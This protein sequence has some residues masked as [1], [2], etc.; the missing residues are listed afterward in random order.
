MDHDARVVA[1]TLR[2]HLAAHDRPLSFLFGAGTSASVNTAPLDASGKPTGYIPLIP[3][4]AGLTAACRTQVE[5]M[6][7]AQTQAWT[8]LCT[9]C[10]ALS[11][12]VDI[13]SILSR[14]RTKL[15]ALLPS[16][17]LSGLSRPQWEA[18]DSAVRM[19]IADLATPKSIP[20]RLPHHA[21][22]R[23][24]RNTTRRRAVEVFTTNYDVLFETCFDQLRVPHFDGFIGSQFSY[25][26]ADAV[27]SEEHLP[28]PSWVRLW[29]LHGSV[30]WTQETVGSEKRITRGRPVTS[31]ELILPSHRKYDES[32][33]QPYRSL[34]DRLGRILG[35]DDAL[36]I[37]CGFGFRDQHINA[38]VLDA[39]EHHPRTHLIILAYDPVEPEDTVAK[40]AA[41]HPNIVVL[42][43]NAGLVSGRYGAWMSPGKADDGLAVAT[44]GLALGDPS[45]PHGVRLHA[46]DFAVFCAFLRFVAGER[47]G[48]P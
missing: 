40:W 32:R 12:P 5:A 30:S 21:F 27:E 29:K 1:G 15:D 48:G 11:H 10:T 22:A 23:W 28:V 39:L 33:K 42:A 44:G 7:A 6:G 2:D 45:M 19:R 17:S 34:M 37:A 31:G 14:V 38:V 41:E 26:S 4:V 43:P 3:A 47:A 9:E 20:S 35:R 25:F 36:L 46:G 8:N 13:E 18:V 16:D 24:L